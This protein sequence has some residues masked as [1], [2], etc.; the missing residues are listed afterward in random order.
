MFFALENNVRCSLS[1]IGCRPEMELVNRRKY[2]RFKI[3]GR[4]FAYY[5]TRSPK[6]AEITDISIEG[7]AFSYVGIAEKVNQPFELEIILPD[8]TRLMEKLPC[9]T[10][11]D[12]KLVSG[13][14]DGRGTRRCSVQFSDLT[15]DQRVKIE[16]FIENYCWRVS[17]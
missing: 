12:C 6:I 13:M 3:D 2:K 16:D 4:A 15:D 9:R 10:V 17:K 14:D 11:S 5:E 7:V 1:G 8:S